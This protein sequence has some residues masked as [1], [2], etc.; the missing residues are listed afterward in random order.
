MMFCIQG[1]P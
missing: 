1:E